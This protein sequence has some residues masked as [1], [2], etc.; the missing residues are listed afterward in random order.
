MT[1]VEHFHFLFYIFFS[2]NSL[3][4]IVHLLP[5]VANV[6]TD[7]VLSCQHRTSGASN[8]SQ[9]GRVN[10]TSE[11]CLLLDS[12][13]GGRY[14]HFQLALHRIWERCSGKSQRVAVTKYFSNSEPFLCFSFACAGIAYAVPKEESRKSVW[15]SWIHNWFIAIAGV[16]N[17]SLL[18]LF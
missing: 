12:M 17:N 1:S 10:K 9:G 5:V 7:W 8:W 16:L 11:P 15:F 6:D 3:F 18:P 13:L 4:T 14:N 2:M